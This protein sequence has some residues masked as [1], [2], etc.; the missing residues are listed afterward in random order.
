VAGH[1][2][3]AGPAAAELRTRIA[4]A[5]DP[6]LPPVD[7]LRHATT[8]AAPRAPVRRPPGH[9]DLA[10]IRAAR[11]P[12][13]IWPDWAIRLT[14]DNA[15]RHDRFRSSALI[16]LLLPHSDLPLNQITAL[17]SG[18]LKRHVAGYQMG[19]LTGPA[20]VRILTELA[21]ALDA[22][23]IPVNYQRRRDLA[24]STTL[25]DDT[26][27]IRIARDAGMRASR[28]GHARRYLYEL[29][30]GCPAPDNRP[31]KRTGAR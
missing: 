7:R 26:T 22:R 13:Q 29:L 25:I 16:A 9:L 15:A 27:W 19:K 3:R 14:D 2:V 4:R 17:V 18:Q 21:F 28:A 30:T 11:L 12:D 8:L 10:V 6:W 23:D 24:T 5:R 1:C 31:C 20:A